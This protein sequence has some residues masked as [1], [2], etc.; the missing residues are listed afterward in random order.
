MS[1]SA[2][3]YTTFDVEVDGGR[4]RVGR[5]GTSPVV[6]LAA[7]GI[8]ANHLSWA[9]VAEALGPDVSLVAPDL[10][11]R[12]GSSGLPGPFGMA[13]H[14]R[15]LVAVVEALG[16]EQV[17]LVGHSMGA[18]VANTMAAEH[19]QHLTSVV[20]VDGGISLPL[21]PGL[22]VDQVLQ[23]VIGPSVAR[24]GMTF[25]D[26]DAYREY[27]RQHPSLGPYWNEAIEDYVSYDLVGEPG[28]M[29]SNVSIDAVRGDGA[30]TLV[31]GGSRDDQFR[32]GCDA[33]L[34]RAARGML[35]TPEPLFADALVEP[36][37]PR[38]RITDVGLVPDTNHFTITMSPHG[39]AAVADQIRKAVADA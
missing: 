36:I 6:V 8:T 13:A 16:V 2:T 26:L 24:L 25:D 33:V 3:S 23:A 30:D 4:L 17:V 10:R 1:D 27:W 11:G 21:A 12:G 34:L 9:L 20:L 14:A 7:H 32:L 18:Y 37:L 5:W 15:D 28:A 19:P 31:E 29:R 39:A 22:D 38:T 35:D